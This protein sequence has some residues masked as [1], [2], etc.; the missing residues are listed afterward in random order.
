MNIRSECM[1]RVFNE[2]KE[3]LQHKK[4]KTCWETSYVLNRIATVF[5]VSLDSMS[6]FVE[7]KT[8]FCCEDCVEDGKSFNELVLDFHE[9]EGNRGTLPCEYSRENIWRSKELE[10]RVFGIFV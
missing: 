8:A 4:L 10:R 7:K 3:D 6:N 9:S 2:L 1:K 5:Y